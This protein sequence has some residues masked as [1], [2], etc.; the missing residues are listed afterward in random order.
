MESSLLAA[1]EVRFSINSSISVTA[2]LIDVLIFLKVPLV[3]S[4]A[5]C[6]ELNATFP[7]LI[8]VEAL[9]MST[10]ISPNKLVI[11]WTACLEFSASFLTSPA[12][13]ENPLPA[14]PARAASIAALSASKFVWLAIWL[15]ESVIELTYSSLLTNSL[16]VSELTVNACLSSLKELSK[17][18]IV[19]TPWSAEESV[20]RT[21]ICTLVTL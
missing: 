20:S 2:S 6:W 19:S 16:I 9:K 21:L 17:V 11:L 13:T 4:I 1:T 14:S 10:L 12:T 3:D 18:F 7:V 15:I 8:A 5:S